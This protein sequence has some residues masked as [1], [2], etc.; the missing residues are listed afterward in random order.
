[1]SPEKVALGEDGAQEKKN[2]R[3]PKYWNWFGWGIFTYVFWKRFLEAAAGGTLPQ[4]SGKVFLVLLGIYGATILI[5]Y[6][7]YRLLKKIWPGIPL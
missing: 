2:V 7:A 3:S 6:G 5:L 4:N 1:V